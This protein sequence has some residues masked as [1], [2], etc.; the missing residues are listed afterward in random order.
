[1]ITS[2]MWY[3]HLKFM[4]KIVFKGIANRPLEEG[5]VRLTSTGCWWNDG[6]LADGGFA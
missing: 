4:L 2:E 5:Y 1:M 6:F 3:T